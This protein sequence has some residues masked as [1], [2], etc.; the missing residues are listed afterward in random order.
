MS[1]VKLLIWDDGFDAL[2]ES[3]R[4]WVVRKPK[5][6]AASPTRLGG[7]RACCLSTQHRRPCL[8][9]DCL[10]FSCGRNDEDEPDY[11]KTGYCTNRSRAVNRFTRRS[12]LSP[13]LHPAPLC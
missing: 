12:S 2:E 13:T 3:E 5:A 7:G 9:L 11:N 6:N 4:L 8:S 10:L 1:V